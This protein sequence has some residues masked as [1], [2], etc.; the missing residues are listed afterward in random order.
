MAAGSAT[1]STIPGCRPDD[2]E[3]PASQFLFPTTA[4]QPVTADFHRFT[5]QRQATS[6]TPIRRL[7]HG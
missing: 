3:S 6:I 4:F 2:R 1:L 7:H 5:M